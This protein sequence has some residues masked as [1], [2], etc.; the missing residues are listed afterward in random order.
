MDA[1]EREVIEQARWLF[2]RNGIRSMTMDDVSKEMGISKKTLYLYVKNKAELVT[3]VMDRIIEGDTE[4]VDAI[5]AKALNSIDELF[6]IMSYVSGKLKDINPS[7]HYDLEKYYP[8]A[9]KNFCNFKQKYIFECM[10]KNINKGKQEGLYREDLN[11]EVITLLFVS[12][13][14]LTFDGKM[15]PPN[16]F[17]FPEVYLEM[18]RYHI[19]G[20]ASD[21]GLKY[22]K[23]KVKQLKAK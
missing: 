23:K 20:I 18:M 5:C 7:I 13:M 16:K 1:K 12:K 19:R 9:W 8:K 17:S 11:A 21:E 22:L 4:I 10:L 14:D 2:L 3:K 15:F 6:E